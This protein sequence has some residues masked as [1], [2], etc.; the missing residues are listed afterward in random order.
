MLGA[1]TSDEPGN[2]SGDVP[3]CAEL[4]IEMQTQY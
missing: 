2:I 4:L 1:K 3:V